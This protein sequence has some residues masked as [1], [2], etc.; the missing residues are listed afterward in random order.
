MIKRDEKHLGKELILPQTG[1][2][3]GG[4]S[5]LAADGQHLLEV[6]RRLNREVAA[7]ADARFAACQQEE[8]Q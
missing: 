3:G 8:T 5:A 6:F 4:R 7:F 1:G 2:I